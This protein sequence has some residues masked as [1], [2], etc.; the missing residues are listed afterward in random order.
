MMKRIFDLVI[1]A[2][3]AVPAAIIFVI[4]FLA[5]RFSLGKPVFFGQLRGGLYGQPF[6]LWKFR[7]MTTTCDE[8]GELLADVER[9]TRL[10]HFLR[11]SS[12]DELPSLWNLL[13][14][15]I[16]LVGPRPFI[17]DYLPLYSPDQRRRHS[18][19]PG[20]T[21]WA[22]VNGRNGLT[23]EQKFELDIWYVDN[24]SF[25]LDLKIIMMTVYAVILS[26]GVDAS[27]DV[28]MSRFEG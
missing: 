3:L 11:A 8:H 14:G 10:G 17:A 15:D 23:W 22:Q 27:S 18:V 16:S 7:S 1:L 25:W 12:M 26:K 21:G 2:M 4:V 6:C 28:T 9:I 5:I 20:I 13:K 19:R 24:R